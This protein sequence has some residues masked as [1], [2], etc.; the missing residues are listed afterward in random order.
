VQPKRVQ[1]E[2]QIAVV[3]VA[4]LFLLKHR[5]R[6]DQVLLSLEQWQQRHLQQAPR[7]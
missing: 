6:V 4:G 3:A 2:Q 1:Q 7:L 5:A